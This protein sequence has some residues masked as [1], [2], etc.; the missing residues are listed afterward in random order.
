MKTEGPG[1]QL[2]GSKWDFCLYR[3]EILLYGKEAL[4]FALDNRVEVS[5][6]YPDVKIFSFHSANKLQSHLSSKKCSIYTHIIMQVY[7]LNKTLEITTY[8]NNGGAPTRFSVLS[9]GRGVS[10]LLFAQQAER[11][12]TGAAS[13]HPGR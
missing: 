13:C 6:Q 8:H 5:H 3:D 9:D 11:K 2:T 4:S 10:L 1:P 12:D 7:R